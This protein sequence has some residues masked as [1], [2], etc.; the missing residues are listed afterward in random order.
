MKNLVSVFLVLLC[1]C[2]HNVLTEIRE[3]DIVTVLVSDGSRYK[4]EWSRQR[5]SSS[6]G[7]THIEFCRTV[8]VNQQSFDAIFINRP[9]IGKTYFFL[10]GRLRTAEEINFKKVIVVQPQAL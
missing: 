4:F 6:D 5:V 2:A 7:M 9:T 1:A 3:G 10:N 8:W